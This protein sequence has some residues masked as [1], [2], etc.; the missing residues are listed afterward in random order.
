VVPDQLA[1][2]TA[3]FIDASDA[4]TDNLPE[5]TME[6]ITIS[7]TAASPG[8]EQ[9]G[10]ESDVATELD[11]WLAELGLTPIERAERDEAT[12][13]DIVLDGRKRRALRITLILDPQVALIAY[14]YLAPPIADSFR[15]SYRQL[16]RWNDELP[17]AK[18]AVTEDERPVLTLEAA[19][20]GL[21]LD[22]VGRLLARSLAIS[23]LIHDQAI[24]LM[25]ELRRRHAKLVEDQPEPDPAGVA[26]LDRYASDVAEL[27]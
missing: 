7:T 14:V 25:G 6:A 15:K 27:A 16:L 5:V 13:W 17:F 18:F 4:A 22:D 9:A 2:K 19:A 10:A 1:V 23:D 3:R 8:T 20:D 11:G 21:S 12:S 24:A 26:L